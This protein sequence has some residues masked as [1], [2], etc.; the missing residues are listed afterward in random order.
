M[1]ESKTMALRIILCGYFLFSHLLVFGQKIEEIYFP[2]I[3]SECE[4]EA[5]YAPSSPETSLRDHAILKLPAS[6]SKT[7]V[8]T[9]LVYMAHGAGG[10]VSENSWFLNQFDLQ[11]QLL[12]N[13]YAV[14]DVNGGRLENFGSR[15]AVASAYKAWQ[16]IIENYNV[17]PQIIVSGYSMGGLTSTNFVYSHSALVLAHV[18]YS[19]VLDLYEQ[20]WQNPWLK[21]T[22]KELAEVYKFKNPSG[23]TF[24]SCA[25]KGQNPIDRGSFY[26]GKKRA[27]LY[28]VPVKIWHG[29]GDRVV[30]IASSHRFYHEIKAGGGNIELAEIESDDHG[31]SCGNPV[32]NKELLDYIKRFN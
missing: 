25:V 16:Y 13:G 32:M 24:D 1:H 22:R 20:A 28:P 19:P 21:S 8:P 9:R 27:I 30:K 5:G 17:Y 15:F 26:L 23:N 7:G 12:E 4:V 18:M 6:Y 3:F 29:T 2:V 10:G 14:F 31:L 11:N